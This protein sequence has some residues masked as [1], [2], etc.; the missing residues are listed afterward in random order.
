[1]IEIEPRGCDIFTKLDRRESSASQIQAV[2][3]E[4]FI[5]RLELEI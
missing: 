1:V 3:L 2:M 5:L 4:I